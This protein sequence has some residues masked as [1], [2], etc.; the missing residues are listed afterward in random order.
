[1]FGTRKRKVEG[2][3]FRLDTV[4]EFLDASEAAF[5]L[6]TP[7][8]RVG[9]LSAA[10]EARWGR[11]TGEPCHKVLLNSGEPCGDCPLEEVLER[12]ALARR[13]MWMFS[14]DG[15][16]ERENIYMRAAGP[17][18]GS[19]LM[20]VVSAEMPERKAL[21]REVM[22]ERELSR[23]LLESV[24]ALVIRLDRSGEISL[25]NKAAERVTGY[26]ESE[27]KAGGGIRFLVPAEYQALAREYFGSPPLEPRATEAV[28]IPLLNKS[29]R[30]R[31]VSWTYSP[32][33]AGDGRAD[34]AIALGQDVSERFARRRQAEKLAEEL[35]VVNAILSKAQSAA[36]LDEMLEEALKALLT[37]PGY[38][39]GVAYLITRGSEEAVLAAHRGFS[40]ATPRGVVRGPGL[41]L[42]PTRAL[43]SGLIEM[44]GAD[45]DMHPGMKSAV[46]LEELKG[47]VAIPIFIAGRPAAMV[48]LGH[49]LDP[50]K[51]EAGLDL[52]KAAADA[53][54]LGAEKARMRQRAEERAREAT[55]LLS[56]AQNLTG[57]LDLTSALVMV[58]A[59]AAELLQVDR[60]GIWLF[61][62]AN[63]ALVHG[64]GHDWTPADSKPE[65]IPIST[66]GAAGE[67]RRTLKPVMVVDAGS[68]PRMPAAEVARH[69]IKSSLVVPLV[70]DGRFAGTLTL[71]MTSRRRRFTD[72][73]IELMESFARQAS[74]AMR[75]ASLVEELRHSEERYRVLADSSLVGLLVHDGV[76]VLYANTRAFE[77]VGYGPEDFRSLEDIIRL[78]VPR[79]RERVSRLI[80]YFV[81]GG[82]PANIRL[83]LELRRKDGSHVVVDTMSNY[84]NFEGQYA[85]MVTLVDNTQ[86][87]E[88]EKALKASE[89]RY[90][91]LVETS[92]DAIIIAGPDGRMKF[93]NSASE[94]LM[95]MTAGELLGRNI[96]SFVHPDERSEIIRDFSRAW[97]TGRGVTR[98]PI[99]VLVQGERYFEA[100]TS[101]LGE[102]GP[103]ADA[104]VIV[105]DVTERETAQ[106]MI[107]ES[108]ERYRT[109]VETS[110]DLIMMTNRA[111]E[112]LYANPAVSEIFG[113]SQEEIR[114]RYFFE[115][116]SMEDRER[117]SRDFVND[118]RIGSTI[119]NY[120]LTIRGRD[121]STRQIEASSGLVGWPSEDAVQIYVIRDVTERKQR[122][123]DREL[124]LRID[125]AMASIAGMFVDPDDVYE[126]ISMTVREAGELLEAS[127]AF[128]VELSENRSTVSRVIEW[129]ADGRREIG[130]EIRGAASG[131]F[132]WW[133]RELQSRGEV[134]FSDKAELPG[135]AR[136]ETLGMFTPRAAAI[137]PFTVHGE[138]AGVLG[139]NH[140][141]GERSWSAHEL[142]LLREIAGTISRAIERKR[143]VEQL[144]RSERFRTRITESIGEGLF[145]LTDGAIS[146]VNNQM[147][148]I[149]GYEAE[150]MIGRSPGF[151]MEYPGR[152]REIALEM[153][154][155]LRVEGIYMSEEGARRKDG[156]L[157][158][159]LISITSLGLT[160]EG[161]DEL[162][163]VVR[164]VT[165]EKRMQAIATAAAEAY[166]TIFST[167]G[168]AMIVHTMEGEIREANERA[169][170]YSGYARDELCR[171]NVKDL[172]TESTGVLFGR[173]QAEVKR[174]GLTTFETDLLRKDGGR[175]PVEITSRRTDVWGE[176]VVLSSCRDTTERHKAE[177]ENRRRTAQLASLNE[178]VKAATSSL[179]LETI[180]DLVLKVMV[181]VSGGE[182]GVILLR[183]HSTRSAC[184]Q[185]SS[186]GDV[187]G[188]TR[189]MEAPGSRES[190]EELVRGLDSSRLIDAGE[191]VEDPVLAGLVRAMRR[192]DRSQVLLV[193]LRSG[194]ATTG[195]IGMASGGGIDERDLGFYDAAGAEIGVAV[196]NALIY[197]QLTAEHER[198]S[199]LY[200]TA[201]GI[202]GELELNTLLDRTAEEAARAV[203][204]SHA[205][206][207]LSDPPSSEFKWSASFNLALAS[208]SG[209]NISSDRGIG[210]RV[211]ESKRALIISGKG[212]GGLL[213]AEP[214]AA[215]LGL[216]YGAAVPLVS[217]DKA[218]GILMLLK[219]NESKEL[220][221]ED[222]LL[223]EAIGRQ[224]GV[225]IENARLYEETRRHLEAVEKAH[226][227]LKVL[228]RMK[229]DFVST[230]SHELRSP[231]AV[232]EGFAKTMVEHFD[233]I[234][235]ETERESLEIIL[236]KSVAL[237]GLIANILDMS[238]IEEG[239]LEVQTEELELVELCERVRD[240]QGTAGGSHRLEIEARERPIMVLAD[241]KKA[242]V[243]LGNLVRNAVKFSP[244]GGTVRISA[245]VVGRVAE[246]SVSDEGIGIPAEELDRVFGRFYQ[247]DSGETR[248]FPG[249]GLGLYI[250][251][252][253][254]QAMGGDISVKS[255]P[256]QGSVFTFTLPL[257]R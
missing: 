182:P 11:V 176:T 128:F 103:D 166:S 204:A 108:E 44:T 127:R 50:G 144:G 247:V 185:M 234:D 129:C 178:I 206:V 163:A 123:A 23:A 190:L 22:R 3:S 39:C 20:A 249:S 137:V 70:T 18:D 203:G 30:R 217:G 31:M 60:C 88:A 155:A 241:R 119:P 95:G 56:V 244:D 76:D 7:D 80:R 94:R 164:D 72:R 84:V 170:M 4:Q 187:P 65:S 251:R 216:R 113:Y 197:R 89:Q 58:A 78:V 74:I 45:G 177:A 135:G 115:F 13:E 107:R 134:N 193:P 201:Q 235:R 212:N 221:A 205:L 250:T 219:E 225:A 82:E 63:Q 179:D 106:R 6:I 85:F 230:V 52:L 96:Y 152:L 98:Y 228:D 51:A 140:D 156:A 142:N 194:D 254:V 226:E 38:R 57:T 165:R 198:L 41:D 236:K 79:Q 10:A 68:D 222:V 12:G 132:N 255:E 121:G 162:V 46:E 180:L 150:E 231:L 126:A 189:L 33:R 5:L 133:R 256:S 116:I 159:T 112:I 153:L 73:D 224:A 243:A 238:R 148:E 8:R 105:R 157:I 110:R 215:V 86:R 131:D 145:V 253:L 136:R 97:E 27:I 77:I 64:A 124:Q 101:I 184:M 114:G 54:Q 40:K 139:L 24:N 67:A 202:S 104:M 15:W 120:P 214:F 36:V 248:S 16:T 21:E 143:W 87:V 2:S 61:D 75:K 207:A 186:V 117:A 223:L 175:T 199:L 59:D 37:L 81:G 154:D 62:E 42:F 168:D 191:I 83:E 147:C 200:R 109:I 173:R 172:V 229:S 192:P 220:T 32:L 209:V 146:W 210:G 160:E 141:D 71:D 122:E 19:P 181:E 90:R 102:P 43:A 149:C 53:L 118:W 171:M 91:A 218:L 167:A 66:H 1:M 257:A 17:A 232:I 26:T 183:P 99:H 55:A 245:G 233:Q 158:E 25:V 252:E 29:G 242:E 34:G 35:L 138:M 92:T 246:V 196:E 239:R 151:L 100:A 47:A 211:V 9:Y 208:L 237:E 69:G 213:D 28:L 14:P 130:E 111:G 227:K 125:E 240:D 49:D 195:M 161:R 93:V 169:T 188:M 48:I 174:D